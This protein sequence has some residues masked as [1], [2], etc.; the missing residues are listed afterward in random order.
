MAK[1][2]LK[3]YVG[4]S[5]IIILSVFSV[6][7]GLEFGLPAVIKKGNV[8]LIEK[9]KDERAARFNVGEGEWSN[10][11]DK[12]AVVGKAGGGYL[13]WPRIMSSAATNNGE[14]KQ[15]A[16]NATFPAPVWDE[17]AE[18]Y[19]YGATTATAYQR[20]DYPAFVWIEN[21]EYEG[22]SDWRLPTIDELQDL[23]NYGQ[24]YVDCD[25]YYVSSTIN[26]ASSVLYFQF[27]GDSTH[28]AGV[29][30]PFGKA[31]LFLVH[32]VRDSD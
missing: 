7:S 23:Y 28:Y 13:M 9:A 8:K 4:L 21:L 31:G 17:K 30:Y 11:D 6:C 15:W 12:L 22:Y 10:I 26:D 18:K 14:T 32:A 19:D 5:I 16:T 25:N 20:R 24:D 29:K 27:T 1:K 3:I 2:N